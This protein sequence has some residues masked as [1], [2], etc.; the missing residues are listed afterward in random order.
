MNVIHDAL[1]CNGSMLC[2]SLR[3]FFHTR[4]LVVLLRRVMGR[5]ITLTRNFS[6]SDEVNPVTFCP[7]DELTGKKEICP[8]QFSQHKRLRPGVSFLSLNLPLFS[9]KHTFASSVVLLLKAH[10]YL[11]W[12]C[13]SRQ[14]HVFMK[15]HICI[16]FC[17]SV[18]VHMYVRGV[19]NGEVL[20]S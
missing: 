5:Y 8:P 19:L 15:T 12:M 14:I 9:R 11:R 3:N 1:Q 20:F 18:N 16:I 2:S 6:C 7:T 13:A 4:L 17:H 10:I